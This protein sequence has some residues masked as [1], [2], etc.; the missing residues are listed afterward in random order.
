MK[1][2]LVIENNFQFKRLINYSI[3]FFPKLTNTL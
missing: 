3:N 1:K 2:Q